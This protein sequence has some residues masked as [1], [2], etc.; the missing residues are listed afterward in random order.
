[1][2]EVSH[3]RCG[4]SSILLPRRVPLRRQA[5]EANAVIDRKTVRRLPVVLSVPFVVVVSPFRQRV[6]GCLGVAVEHPDGRVRI[7]EPRVE[8]VARVVGEVDLTVEAGEDALRLEAVLVV[9]TSLRCVRAPHLR[10]IREDVVR[11]ILVG[12]RTAIGLAGVTSASTT[13]HEPRSVATPAFERN[14]GCN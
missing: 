12:E 3:K 4:Q 14:N 6:L 9:E 7:G 10:H 11:D 5:V 1:M 2:R 8:R 13:E